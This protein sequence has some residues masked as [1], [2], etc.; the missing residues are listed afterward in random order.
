MVGSGWSCE[1]GSAASGAW[2]AAG[3][4][5]STGLEQNRHQL[6]HWCTALAAHRPHSSPL[7]YP[8]GP[9]GTSLR[10]PPARPGCVGTACAAPP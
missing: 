9:T 6:C 5:G 3:R 1:D 2:E 7:L 4:E 8:P 10:R